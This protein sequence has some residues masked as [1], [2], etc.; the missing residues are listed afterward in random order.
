MRDF[1]SRA[2]LV[3]RMHMTTVVVCLACAGN[4][5]DSI[6]SL[7]LAR[8][9]KVLLLERDSQHQGLLGTGVTVSVS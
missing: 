3:L 9:L 6:R 2:C 7:A 4:T 5:Y 8:K 1:A